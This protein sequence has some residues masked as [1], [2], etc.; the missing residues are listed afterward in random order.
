MPTL[1]TSMQDKTPWMR[2]TPIRLSTR[3]PIKAEWLDYNNHM[4]VAYYVLIFDH[5]GVAMVGELGA[6]SEL[7]RQ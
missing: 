7:H 2:H 3:L 6:E 5:A 1:F 4:N